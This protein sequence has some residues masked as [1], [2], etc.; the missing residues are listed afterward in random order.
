MKRKEFTIDLRGVRLAK[1]VHQKLAAALPFPA[2]YGHNYDALHDFLTEF[3]SNL[4][5]VF[6]HAKSAP[7][8]LR[9]VC[10]DAVSETP[11]LEI[12]FR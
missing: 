2:D 9:N 7:E 12:E 10:E 1:T 3:G 5:L 11:G 4:K 8:T 6:T